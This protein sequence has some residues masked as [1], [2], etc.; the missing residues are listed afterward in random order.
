MLFGKLICHV[1]AVLYPKV[2]LSLSGCRRSFCFKALPNPKS[3]DKVDFS[4]I[5]VLFVMLFHLVF[6]MLWHENGHI[7][8]CRMPVNTTAKASFKWSVHP[9]YKKTKQIFWPS[10]PRVVPNHAVS[11]ICPGFNTSVKLCQFKPKLSAWLDI[12]RR[13]SRKC[14]LVIWVNWA[15][16]TASKSPY[17]CDCL[18][19]SLAWLFLY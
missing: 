17:Q 4:E 19:Q 5:S 10:I 16:H 12:M 11:F 18:C 3:F 13:E 1:K 15:F 14:V 2:L 7:Y 6:A 8:W 9:K